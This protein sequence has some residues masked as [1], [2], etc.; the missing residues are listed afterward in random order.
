MSKDIRETL[1]LKTFDNVLGLNAAF[2]G[3]EVVEIPLGQLYPF[4]DHPFRV[5]DDEKMLELVES[6]K[7][8]GVL[9]PAIVRKK[10]E[11]GYE[12]ISGHRRKRACE[13]AGLMTMPVIIKELDD[14]DAT[15]LMVDANIQRENVLP[16]E[17]AKAY[18]MKN[19]FG[20]H[21][22]ERT[23][24]TSAQS[25]PKLTTKDIG[26]E[27][28]DSRTKVQNFIRL[29]Y[30]TPELLE[31]VDK[32]E[33][34]FITGVHLSFLEKREQEWV[35]SVLKESGKSILTKK[36]EELRK[37]SKKKE[38]NEDLVY[39]IICGKERI[40]RTISFHEKEL[41]MYFPEYLS[42]DEIKDQIIEIL[43]QW[44]EDSND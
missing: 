21:Q 29:N 15:I 6:I 34:G 3:N 13:L 43:K 35:L 7:E 31:M 36:A 11:Y 14:K 5:V 9:S 17:R 27:N 8:K 20:S 28:G 41:R 24:L 26:K 33:I 32:N 40:H 23:D 38:L 42:L 19:D 18:K 44:K 39:Q 12:I 37:L 22:G 4:K 16:S 25:G 30:L 2:E 1:K 10:D